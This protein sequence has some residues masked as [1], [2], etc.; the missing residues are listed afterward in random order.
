MN[1]KILK[2][3]K[4]ISFLCI[5]FLL[6]EIIYVGY[7]LMYNKESLYFDGVNALTS[8][9]KSYIAVGS[10]NNNDYKYEK[11]ILSKYNSK[12]EKVFEKIYNKGY[13][14]AFFDVEFDGDFII[15]VGSYEKD[16]SDHNN[17][18][19]SA[20]LV[21]YDIN[22]DIVFENDL[23]ILDNSKFTSVTVVDDGYLVTGQS[24]Y[25]STKIGSKEGGAVLIKYDK[26]GKMLWKSTYGNN[27]SAVFNNLI[28]LND[29]IYTVGVDD[30]YLGLICKYNLDG[31]FITYND[32]KWTDII[33]FSDICNI[34]DKIY[35][36]GANRS[37]DNW[38]NS[39]IVEYDTDCT[40]IKETVYESDGINRFN[41]MQ[42]DSNDNIIVIGSLKLNKSSKDSVDVFNY[43]AII[44]KYKD[45]LEKVSIIKYGD[46]KDDFFTDIT[47]VD[48]NYLVSGY[49]SYEDGS[50]LSKFLKYSEALKLLGVE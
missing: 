38:T 18:V 22:G 28:V 23:S 48:K 39:M 5:I 21:K 49:S 45:N 43:D 15:A 17:S 27:K 7:S 41:K 10:N 30:N 13:N 8:D 6:I 3:L 1:S 47:I 32:Y 50:Y 14:G 26:D 29:S 33:G 20:L 16:E 2:N 4:I 40:Y 42:V 36:C 37:G 12:K 34:G 9:G 35:V 24:V 31:E 25:K 11:A 46:E 44:G 19:R